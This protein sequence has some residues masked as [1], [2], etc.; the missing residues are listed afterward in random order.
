MFEPCPLIDDKKCPHATFSLWNPDTLSVGRDRQ[1]FCGVAT[2][3][4]NRVFKLPKCWK[5]MTAYEKNKY[6][7]GY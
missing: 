3:S 7:K 6:N 1:L 2:A 4:D 5:D